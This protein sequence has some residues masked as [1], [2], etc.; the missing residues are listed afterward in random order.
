M[1][2]SPRSTSAA[3]SSRL[4]SGE[5]EAPLFSKASSSCR[6]GILKFSGCISSHLTQS[7]RIAPHIRTCMTILSSAVSA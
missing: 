4:S 3:A 1:L 5:G 6:F 7:N 2:R